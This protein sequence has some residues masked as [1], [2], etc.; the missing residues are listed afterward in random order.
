MDYA[1]HDIV[2][3]YLCRRVYYEGTVINI[4]FTKR[5]IGIARE[6]RDAFKF[7]ENDSKQ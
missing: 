1:Y 4:L 7:I 3:F 6:K 2:H 5:V